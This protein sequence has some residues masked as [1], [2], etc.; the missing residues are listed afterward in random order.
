L[1]KLLLACALFCAFYVHARITFSEP[2][3]VSWLSNHYVKAMSGDTTACEDYTDDAEVTLNAGG[4]RGTW[5][6]EGGKNEICG[7]YKQAAAV[8]TVMQASTS[9]NF[10]DVV[11]SRGGFPWMQARVTYK[12]KTTI[13]AAGSIPAAAAYSDNTIVLVRTLSGLKI[14]SVDSKSTGRL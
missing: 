7:Y 3:I 5:E 14:K 1:K 6:V 4:A 2:R 11:I 13:Q 8:F 9:S 12:Q 10:T